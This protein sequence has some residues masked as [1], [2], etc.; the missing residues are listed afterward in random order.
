MDIEKYIPYEHENAV[1]R[2]Q[3]STRT[4]L[5]DR[6]V[7]REIEQA[8][9]RGCVI[10]NRQDGCGYY[11]TNDLDEIEQQYRRQQGRALAVLCQQ[12]HLRRLLKAA[13]REV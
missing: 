3:L 13:G 7:R 9:R 8:R 1:T 6:V 11:Q 5:P 10:I 12:K 4:S 2:A